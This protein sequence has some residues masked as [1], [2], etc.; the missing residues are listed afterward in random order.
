MILLD[1][2]MPG[3][4]G[5]QTLALIREQKLAEGTPVIAL[6][7]D[8]IVG[9]RDNYIREGFT[10]Y[11]SKPVM[12]EALE[13]ILLKYLD[14]SLIRKETAQTPPE[15]DSGAAEDGEKPLVIAIS[16][17]SEKLR[18]ISGPSNSGIR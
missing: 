11:L 17:S 18:R 1:Q 14:P 12:Y 4:S 5:T 8:A 3:L 2:M 16:E 6:T 7:A 15:T 9:A 10:D 13:T